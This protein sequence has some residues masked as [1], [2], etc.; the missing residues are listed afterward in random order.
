MLE[1][2]IRAARDACAA[3]EQPRAFVLIGQ[4]GPNVID[5]GTGRAPIVIDAEG[6]VL[7]GGAVYAWCRTGCCD[8]H[9]KRWPSVDAAADFHGS[10]IL[11]RD[12]TV[13]APAAD[14]AR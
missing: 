13:R 9:P 8:Q 6:I 5:P 2:E 4:G 12:G 10:W 1:Q 11:D 14:Q 7:R 3:I